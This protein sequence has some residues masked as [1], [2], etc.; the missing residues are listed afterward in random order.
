MC[1]NQIFLNGIR[2]NLVVDFGDY[3]IYIPFKG[4][5]AVFVSFQT[6][7]VLND[8]Q[9]EFSGNPRGKFKSNI[10][11]NIRPAITTR[12]RGGAYSVG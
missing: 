12:L 8:V 10:L 1:R 7:I 11:V 9:L 2:M 4:Y 5:F 6:L 3:P